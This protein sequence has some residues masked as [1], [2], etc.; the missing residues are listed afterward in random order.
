M[1]GAQLRLMGSKP[2]LFCL[3]LLMISPRPCQVIISTRAY[4]MKFVILVSALLD[5]IFASG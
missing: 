2:R 5:W 1:P 3:N 4:D